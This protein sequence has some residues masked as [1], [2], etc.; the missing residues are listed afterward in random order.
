M[1]HYNPKYPT[2]EELERHVFQVLQEMFGKVLTMVLEQ[3]DAEIAE[4]RDKRRFRLK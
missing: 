4:A 3:M 1:G 2:L